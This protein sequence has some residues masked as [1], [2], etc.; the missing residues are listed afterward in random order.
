M[1]IIISHQNI[2]KMSE[3]FL[4]VMI[5]SCEESNSPSHVQQSLACPTVPRMFCSFQKTFQNSQKAISINTSYQF[6]T[7]DCFLSLCFTLDSI[8][9]SKRSVISSQYRP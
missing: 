1:S 7:K 5:E 6:A 9:T 3:H 2:T 4:M 8:W